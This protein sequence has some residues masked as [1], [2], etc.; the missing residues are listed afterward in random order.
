MAFK[1]GKIIRDVVHGD[2][3][4]EDRFVSVIDTKEF[5]RLRRIK[6]LSVANMVFP[7][8]EH[9][10]FAHCIGT[11][12]VMRQIIEHFEPLFQKCG[13]EIEEADKNA[14]LVAALLHDIGHGPYSHAFEGV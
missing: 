2:I 8:A 3:F 6:Q 12:H 7:G 10:R 14:A 9:T 4:I 11:F 13:I 1:K 5:Q